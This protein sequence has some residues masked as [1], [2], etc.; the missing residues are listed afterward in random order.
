MK[1]LAILT[2]LTVGIP[3]AGLTDPLDLTGQPYS[4]Y[5]NTNVYSLPLL[6]FNFDTV[7]GGGTGPGN[8]YFVDSTPNAI[9]DSVVIYTGATGTD[10]STNAPGFD[11]AYGVPLIPPAYASIGENTGVTNP[12]NTAGIS[13]NQANTW[14]A[15][16]MALST[17]LA[18][19]TP[20]F[21][22]NNNENPAVGDQNLAAWAKLWITSPTNEVYQDRFSYL[23]NMGA[24]YLSAGIPNGDA[25]LYNPGPVT[26]PPQGYPAT[27]FVLLG[28]SVEGTNENLGTDQAA[29]AFDMPLLNAALT[30][31]FAMS[32]EELVQYTL[33]VD[34]RIGCGD[35]AQWGN[36]CAQVAIDGSYEQLFMVSSVTDL[37]AVPE[38]GMLALLSLGLAGLGWSRRRK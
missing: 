36:Q 20:L 22:F 8:P 27:D 9:K 6:A 7:N 26:N 14:D 28:G 37:A 2:A 17:F 12:G 32:D 25:T 23:S 29:Y 13:N 11:N 19:G 1:K 16:L 4:T 21:F 10:V 18:G 30:A 31:L 3:T 24:P 38:P 34:L 15:S 33:H 5:G 35:P